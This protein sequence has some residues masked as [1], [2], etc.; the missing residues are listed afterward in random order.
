MS[1]EISSCRVAK[2]DAAPAKCQDRSTPF[3]ETIFQFQISGL[4]IKKL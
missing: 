2:Y 1:G 4:N 3:G